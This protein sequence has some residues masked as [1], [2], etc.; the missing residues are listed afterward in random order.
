MTTTTE[1]AALT[2][3]VEHEKEMRERL[4]ARLDKRIDK[5][6]TNYKLTMLVGAIGGLL[7]SAVPG[8]IPA[9]KALAGA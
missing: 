9:L 5:V 1:L 8:A 3:Q 4:E 6:E 7:L 2:V